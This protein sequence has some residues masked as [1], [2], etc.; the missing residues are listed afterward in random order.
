MIKNVIAFVA[1]AAVG[2]TVAYIFTKNMYDGKINEAVESVKEYDKKQIESLRNRAIKAEEWIKMLE[3]K[4]EDKIIKGSEDT[5]NARVRTN[6]NALAKGYSAEDISEEEEEDVDDFVS[7]K[8]Y[9]DGLAL[10]E[11]TNSRE[12][13]VQ[14]L[15]DEFGEI[16]TIEAQTLYYYAYDGVLVTEEEEIIDDVNR[17]VGD[18]LEESGFTDDNSEVIYIRNLL[19]GSDYEITKVFS[20]F[21]E[22]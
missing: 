14:I 2:S 8:N 9:V 3:R 10:S 4:K 7:D 13:P 11:V 12:G 1:G 18:V 19:L 15:A 20:S 6:Y 16:P 5:A 17:V 21:E 22:K